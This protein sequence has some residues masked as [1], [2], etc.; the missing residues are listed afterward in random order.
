M[1]LDVCKDDLIA[2]T[3]TLSS[4]NVSK[5]VNVFALQH[6]HSNIRRQMQLVGW[7]G[8]CIL[9]FFYLRNH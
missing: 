7:I 2:S 5:C 8:Y 1:Y 3:L 9:Y 6:L 4:H